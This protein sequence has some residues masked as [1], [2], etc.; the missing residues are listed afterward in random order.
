VTATAAYRPAATISLSRFLADPNLLGP[1]FAAPSWDAWKV[2]LKAAFGERLTPDET[3]RFR[4][5]AGRDPPTKRVRELWLA[6]GRRGGKDSIAARGR[7]LLSGLW[8]LP[9]LPAAR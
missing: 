6:I 2:T 5:L 7:N 9:A 1:D 8:R 4:E 3:T